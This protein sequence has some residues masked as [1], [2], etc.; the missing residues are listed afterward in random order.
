MAI[1]V[2]KTSKEIGVHF[3]LS[4]AHSSGATF[5]KEMM[6]RE[7]ATCARLLPRSLVRGSLANE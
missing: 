7:P 1:D 5:V 3:N 6:M 4:V 2:R